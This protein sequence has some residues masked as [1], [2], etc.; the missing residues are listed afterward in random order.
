MK[1]IEILHGTRLRPVVHFHQSFDLGKI[2][3]HQKFTGNSFPPEMYLLPCLSGWPP[4]A[5]STVLYV[6][7]S[8]REIVMHVEI[9]PLSD[10]DLAARA[11]HMRSGLHRDRPP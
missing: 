6:A 8:D 4:P 3:F 9:L 11:E 7:N 2:G 10:G 5:A 1:L